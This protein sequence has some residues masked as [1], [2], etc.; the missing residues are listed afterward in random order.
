MGSLGPVSHYTALIAG[1]KYI[2]MEAR[3]DKKSSGSIPQKILFRKRRSKRGCFSPF[4]YFFFFPLR[5]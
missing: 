2:L 1:S 5:M 4:I 3:T